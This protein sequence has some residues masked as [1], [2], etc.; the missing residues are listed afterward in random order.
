MKSAYENAEML[1][2]YLRNKLKALE[3]VN[4]NSAADNSSPFIINFS[5]EGI[6]SEIM[7]HYLESRDIYV[8]SGSACSRGA[9]SSVLTAMGIPDRTADSAIRVSMSRTTQKAELDALCEGIE[10]GHKSLAKNK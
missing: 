5:V 7:L 8:S 9:H 3:F 10:A 6:R 4:I 2:G 1:S